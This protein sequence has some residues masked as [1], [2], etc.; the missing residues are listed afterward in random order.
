MAGRVVERRQAEPR[1]HTTGQASQGLQGAAMTVFVYVDT[2]KQVGDA[3]HIKVFANAD[4]A[5]KWFEENDPEG[6][7]FEYEVLE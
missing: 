5:E 2:S 1:C 4:A 7:A 3:E 6:V